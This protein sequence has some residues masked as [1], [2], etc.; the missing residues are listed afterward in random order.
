MRLRLPFVSRRRY[1]RDLAHQQRGWQK[2]FL[3]LTRRHS[4]A[5]EK[6]YGELSD[7]KEEVALH[8]VAA[9]H[10]SSA[11]SDAHSMGVALQ[12]ALEAHGVDL[13][14]ELARLEGSEL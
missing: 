9:K 2:F 13:R 10:P 14:I 8:I 6:A 12:E 5:L 1:T 4:R 11:L 3:E 7:L